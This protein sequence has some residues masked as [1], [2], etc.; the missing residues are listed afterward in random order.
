MIAQAV[1]GIMSISGYPGRPAGEARADARRHRH[2]MLL[3]ISILGA[4]YEKQRT[5]KGQR[6]ES[7]CRTRCCITSASRSRRRHAA[8]GRSERVGD[9]SISGGNPPVRN[10][11]LARAAGPN[12]YVYVYTSRAE[13]EHWN[14]C[15]T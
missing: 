4:L 11:P 12:D 3:A 7:R 15:C 6:I 13:P 5:G 10:L 9:Q 14:G 2:R 1:G 8:A